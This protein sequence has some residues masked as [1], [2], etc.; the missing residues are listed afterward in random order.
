MREHPPFRHFEHP[1][2]D[3]SFMTG[4]FFGLI[5]GGILGVLFAPDAGENTRRKLKDTSDDLKEKGDKVLEKAGRFVED[6]RVAADPLVDEIEKNVSPLLKRAKE[7]G[8][9]VHSQVIEKIEQLVDDFDN[10]SDHKKSPKKAFR[11]IN[12]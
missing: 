9:D 4:M 1:N 12:R 10:T 5:V 11:G 7:S 3:G 8:K 2:K 6:V